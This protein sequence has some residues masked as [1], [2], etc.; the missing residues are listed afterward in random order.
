MSNAEK[1]KLKKTYQTHAEQELE[2]K[3]HITKGLLQNLNNQRDYEKEVRQRA[4]QRVET[5][6]SRSNS[7]GTLT[8]RSQDSGPDAI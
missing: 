2:K 7:Q 5:A 6:R 4:A 8:Y 1:V 3:Y